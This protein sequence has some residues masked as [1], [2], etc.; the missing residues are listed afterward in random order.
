M[1]TGEKIKLLRKEFG[2]SAEYIADQIGVSPST[3]Y[4][5]ENNEIASMK[6]DNLKAIADLLHT[7]ASSLLGW[8][9]DGFIT[10]DEISLLSHFRQLNE[11]GQ[12]KIVDY[13]HDLVASGRYIKTDQPKLVEEA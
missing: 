11:E 4:R 8:S 12:E 9:P 2:Y 13:I 1:N 3:I 5:Y 7:S 6:I 10:E